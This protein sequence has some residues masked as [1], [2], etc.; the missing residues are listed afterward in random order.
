M[1]EKQNQ[2]IKYKYRRK[3]WSSVFGIQQEKTFRSTAENLLLKTR[4]YFYAEIFKEKN[5]Y[6]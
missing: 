3:E 2:F 6:A 5:Y 1:A 4:V